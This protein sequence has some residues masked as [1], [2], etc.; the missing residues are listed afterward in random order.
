LN[1]RYSQIFVLTARKQKK[2]DKKMAERGI[3]INNLFI[4]FFE[5]KPEDEQG[6][7]L[8]LHG[9]GSRAEK[10]RK[11]GELLAENGY[12]VII[13]DLPGFGK[14]DKPARAWNLDDYCNF[15]NEFVQHLNLEKFYLLGH[16]FGGA[17]AVKCSLKFPEKVNKLFLVG[18]ACFRRKAVRKRLFYIIAKILKIFS[19]LPGYLFLRKGFYKF[20]VR[21]SDYPYAEGI[22]KDIYLKIIKEDLSSFLPLIQT[23]TVIIW[24]ENDKIKKIKEAR[25]LQEK[26]KNSKLEIL[27]NAGHSLYRKY[28]EESVKIIIRYL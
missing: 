22:M 18:A 24:G 23:P 26:I 14:S 3:K 21:R 6:L 17:L 19:F 4:N 1:K 12:K 25:L 10:W 5:F 27:A 8:I 11:V 2:Q 7:F 15:V 20:I 28:P 13:P 16:S 9:W